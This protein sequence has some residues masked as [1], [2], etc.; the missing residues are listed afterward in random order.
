MRRTTRAALVAGMLALGACG[1]GDDAGDNGGAGGASD[2]SPG[3]TADASGAENTATPD[4]DAQ[5]L[6]FAE[7]MRTNGI[8]MPDPGSG[9][10]AFFD[11]FHSTLGSYDRGQVQAAIDE[12][13][14]YFPT[15]AGAGH[16]A[17]SEDQLALAE[18]LRE[19]GLDVPDDLF[20]SGAFADIDQDELTSALES[21]R[22]VVGGGGT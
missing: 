2:V 17:S 15:Y 21:C 14:D 8:D 4:E 1:S 19:Q 3:T 6:V 13:S 16:G 9:Q 10:A 7:C 22:D 20:T 11:A 18:C 5:A 12:C